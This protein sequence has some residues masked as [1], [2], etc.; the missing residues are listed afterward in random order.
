M[1][2]GKILSFNC[3]DA[4]K[5]WGGHRKQNTTALVSTPAWEKSG[6][7]ETCKSNQWGSAGREDVKHH[8]KILIWHLSITYIWAV[9]PCPRRV[10]IHTD[11]LSHPL[12]EWRQFLQ[13]HSAEQS[14]RISA[15]QHCPTAPR[16]GTPHCPSP[17]ALTPQS[18]SSLH[19][20]TLGYSSNDI[21]SRFD[22]SAD[23]ITTHKRL[24]SFPNGTSSF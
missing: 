18:H 16:V 5:H 11:N 4:A 13:A 19:Q 23:Y 22:Y 15:G 8:P 3:K 20:G 6:S 1:A 17:A 24:C 7:A 21:I 12:R 2:K 9:P 10:K 14:C